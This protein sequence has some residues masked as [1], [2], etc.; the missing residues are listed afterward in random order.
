[1]HEKLMFGY[2]LKPMPDNRTL[3]FA[4]PEKALLDLLYM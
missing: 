4:S 1:M 2:H 3:Q